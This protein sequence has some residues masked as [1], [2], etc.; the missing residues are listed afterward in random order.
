MAA[1]A[2]PVGVDGGGDRRECRSAYGAYRSAKVARYEEYFG[3]EPDRSDEAQAYM[4][5]DLEAALPEGWSGLADLIPKEELH[6]QHRSTNLS[7]VLALGPLGA[8]ARSDPSL[9][10]LWGA[11]RRRRRRRRR[12]SSRSSS[13][14]SRS[15]PR[16]SAGSG[17]GQAF[18]RA[19]ADGAPP[20]GLDGS[21]HSEPRARV[22]RHRGAGGESP[23]QPN[24]G[25]LSAPSRAS[26]R[27][28]R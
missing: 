8:A 26:S 7:Q 12:G 6:C 28:R 21:E 17:G 25:S 2:E 15:P 10:W 23:S 16:R 5:R 4:A 24:H 1:D 13:G 27:R 14:S 9:A 11:P 19:T 18:A 3:R 20:L 22:L